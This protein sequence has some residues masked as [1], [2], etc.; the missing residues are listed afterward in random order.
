MARKKVYR[1][2][3]AENYAEA[4]KPEPKFEIRW[5]LKRPEPGT[6]MN[7]LLFYVNGGP[8]GRVVLQ[9]NSGEGWKDVELT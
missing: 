4:P 8:V 9:V 6:L 3:P 2:V 1:V 7:G 5:R